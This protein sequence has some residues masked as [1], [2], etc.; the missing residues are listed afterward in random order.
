MVVGV[1]VPIPISEV[2]EMVG[3]VDTNINVND[4]RSDGSLQKWFNQECW[5][6]PAPRGVDVNGSRIKP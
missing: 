2:V 5:G 4:E 1:V 6:P 3:G